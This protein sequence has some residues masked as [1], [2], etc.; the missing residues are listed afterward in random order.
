ME[1][2][3][4]VIP[5]L[6]RQHASSLP[7]SPAWHNRF[8][9]GRLVLAAGLVIF[10][11]MTPSS[12]NAEDWSQQLTGLDG[13][14]VG[15]ANANEEKYAAAIC[16]SMSEYALK[17][18]A[19]AGISAV[20]IGS[21]YVHQKDEPSR[22]DSLAKPLKITFFVRGTNSGSTY[23]INVR[24]RLSVDYVAAVEAGSADAGRKGELVLW[25]GS[26]TGSGP[27]DGLRKAITKSARE[28]F[29]EEFLQVLESWPKSP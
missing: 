8:P 13:V 5:G 22:P 15:C 16:V 2:M 1:A 18:L 24:S 20:D 4:P 27:R 19:Q 6:R 14:T 17:E 25:E 9:A 7:V 12:S 3:S 10:G 23:A 28:K 26:T 21:W 11:S 29:A